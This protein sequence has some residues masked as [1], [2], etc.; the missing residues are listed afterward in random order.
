MIIDESQ[1]KA[2]RKIV[3]AADA[4]ILVAGAGMSAAGGVLPTFR[5]N[6]G[7]W[8]HYPGLK[9]RSFFT[10]A[11][12]NSFYDDHSATLG[13]YMHRKVLY[14]DTMPSE[15][16][17]L[18]LA[19]VEQKPMKGVL[20][21]TNVDGHAQR[22]GFANVWEVHGSIN[23]WHC[24]SVN[25]TKYR[26][27]VEL[28]VPVDS[29]FI[30]SVNSSCFCDCGQPIRPSIMLF[31]DIGYQ[32]LSYAMQKSVFDQYFV[33]LQEKKAKVCVIEV[34]CGNAVP[35]QRINSGRYSK[36]FSTKV[37]RINKEKES[38]S[39]DFLNL[40]GVDAVKALSSLLG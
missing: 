12:L 24:A 20:V 36:I 7:F 28:D 18:S 25:C 9:G 10:V 37:I 11:S 31:D 21:T 30:A 3:S 38:D 2:A 22:A 26:K 1:L 40:T 15:A 5:D 4:V 32:P 19:L 35:T 27:V 17:R 8:R 33:S 14:R 29:E 6:E 34:G 23:E 39:D 16:Y 13:F